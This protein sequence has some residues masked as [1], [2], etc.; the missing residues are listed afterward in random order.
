M[1]LVLCN[2]FKYFF[3]SFI[4]SQINVKI[5][6]TNIFASN[7]G[8]KKNKNSKFGEERENWEKFS[9]IITSTKYKHSNF[10]LTLNTQ[11]SQSLHY[12]KNSL[13]S[14]F[15]P[16]VCWWD[17]SWHSQ[18]LNSSHTPF[19]TTK[20]CHIY[21]GKLRQLLLCSGSWFLKQRC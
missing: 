17:S 21:I 16:S 5:V 3:K 15:S 7:I 1:L 20:M 12:I 6:G 14:I 8:T 13:H 18:L 19:E 2:L 9:S 10:S 11:F 4:S